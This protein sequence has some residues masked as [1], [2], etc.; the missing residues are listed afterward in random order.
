MRY[1]KT[2]GVLFTVYPPLALGKQLT[3]A[4]RYDKI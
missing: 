4:N 2:A 1:I 3:L